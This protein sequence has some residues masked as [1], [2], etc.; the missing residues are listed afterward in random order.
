M[1]SSIGEP[2]SPGKGSQLGQQLK[3]MKRKHLLQRERRAAERVYTV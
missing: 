1:I 3:Q 2:C